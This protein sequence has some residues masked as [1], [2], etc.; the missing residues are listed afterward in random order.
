MQAFMSRRPAYDG[1]YCTSPYKTSTWSIDGFENPGCGGNQ[2]RCGVDVLEH[3]VN[4]IVMTAKRRMIDTRLAHV[5][6]I[7][8][9]DS[10]TNSQDV[11][12]S[13]C[14]Y[15]LMSRIQYIPHVARSTE[16]HAEQA[17]TFSH[18]T[19]VHLGRQP[20]GI[21]QRLASKTCRRFCVLVSSVARHLSWQNALVRFLRLRA[22]SAP[23][24]RIRHP[25]IPARV[26]NATIAG[27]S[28]DVSNFVSPFYYRY[29]SRTSPRVLGRDAGGRT[30]CTCNASYP[31]RCTPG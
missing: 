7:Q 16:L 12:S 1:G 13:A 21:S 26:R 17:N 14:T 27:L 22:N 29:G 2:Y 24:Y 31:S 18:D 28:T 25:G 23:Y 3:L 15:Q 19:D 6:L 5:H 8:V 30:L 20:S 11:V 9:N 10:F 4:N